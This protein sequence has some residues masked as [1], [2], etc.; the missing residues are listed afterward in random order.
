MERALVLAPPI[1]VVSQ[2]SVLPPLPVTERE[3]AKLNTNRQE[4]IVQ[5]VRC[6]RAMIAVTE[7][8]SAKEF[9]TSAPLESAKPPQNVTG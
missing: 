2:G 7:K 9:R 3:D 5:M 1:H 6:A 4:P 8:G